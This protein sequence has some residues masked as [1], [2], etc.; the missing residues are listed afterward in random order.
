MATVTKSTI[1]VCNCMSS[2]YRDQKILADNGAMSTSL[3]LDG[4]LRARHV[5]MANPVFQCSRCNPALPVV[6]ANDTGHF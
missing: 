5:T 1:A 6:M 2:R 4:E 3:I